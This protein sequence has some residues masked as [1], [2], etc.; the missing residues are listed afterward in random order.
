M[1]A[2]DTD[3]NCTLRT[4]PLKRRG[5]THVGRYYAA[6]GSKRL[7]KTEAET[8]SGAGLRI[9]T[10]YEDSGDPDLTAVRGIRDA[11]IALAQA[12]AIGQPTGSAIYFALEHLPHGYGPE[13]ISGIKDYFEGIGRT[14]SG[15]YK[16][17]CYSNGTTLA[18]LLDAHLIDYAWVSASTSFHGSKEFLKTSRW[19]LAQRKVD[20]DWDGVSVDTN[21]CRGEF[22]SW[23]L[24]AKDAIDETVR[25]M[26]QGPAAGAIAGSAPA[27]TTEAKAGLLDRFD[28]LDVSRLDKLQDLGSRSAGAINL[29][30]KI[31]VRGGATVATVAGGAA[32]IVDPNKGNAALAGSWTSQHPVLLALLVAAVVAV[33]V[34]G[35]AY[36]CLRKAGKG[37]LAAHEQ[38]RY[39]PRGETA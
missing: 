8:L 34:G 36:Y 23:A 14:V 24:P 19:H 31:L 5:V 2:I 13:H 38:K 21:D 37:L 10:V 17:G 32:S 7:S 9:F 30:K 20:L 22:G 35:V 1:I 39:A 26:V 6:K 11:Q 4:G 3:T 15:A 25:Q 27:V 33:L 12:R 16:I 18:A 29:G 28:T